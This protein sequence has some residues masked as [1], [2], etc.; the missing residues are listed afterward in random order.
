VRQATLRATDP[1]GNVSAVTLNLLVAAPGDDLR[2]TNLSARAHVGTGADILI[3]GFVVSGRSPRR[4]LMR[5]IG[6]TLANFGLAG[7]LAD[8]Q[9]T[10]LRDGAT[11][12]MN[13]AWEN[14]PAAVDMRAAFAATGAF[15]LPSGS[16]DAALLAT[17][18]PGGAT[19][20][21]ES[22]TGGTGLA[23]LEIYDATIADGGQLVNLST[24]AIV[25][26]G[27]DA[28][29]PGLVLAGG[30]ARR[31]LVRASGPALAAFGVAGTLADPTLTLYAGSTV[32]ATNDDWNDNFNVDDIRAAARSAGA[33]AFP[34]NG[35]D[36][37]LLVTLAQG[38]YTLQVAAKNGA[39]GVALVEVYL[40]P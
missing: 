30:G 14:Q 15:A 3:P 38:T 23:L 34:E 25:G 10:L 5:A 19:A 32:L 35:K 18:G 9:L 17:L 13:S 28:L 11:L 7:T 29:M 26:A 21:I 8:P 4:L 24:R 1:A 33:F 2:L 37:A 6:P 16:R 39:S 27:S 36:A 22:I 20:K 12:A 31:L 40:L